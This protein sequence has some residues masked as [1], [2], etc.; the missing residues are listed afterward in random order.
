M[1]SLGTHNFIIFSSQLS[2]FLSLS[3]AAVEGYETPSLITEMHLHLQDLRVEY[4]Y[5]THI[6]SRGS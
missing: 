4:W 5:N 1:S 3:E 6:H 2:E